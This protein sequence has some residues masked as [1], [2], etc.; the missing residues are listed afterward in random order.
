[1]S[2]RA[3][4]SPNLTDRGR[5]PAVLRVVTELIAWVTL[6]WGLASYSP[7]WSV[8]ALLVLIG[9]PALFATPGDK[10]QVSRPVP[11]FVTIAFMILQLAGAVWGA[12]LVL[13]RWALAAVCVLVVITTV[14]EIPRWRWL[15][16]ARSS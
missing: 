8:V 9:L 14:A 15:A 7:I 6:P 5:I 16:T 11:G 2:E 1:M 4:T 12:Y 13:P 3:A 10:K